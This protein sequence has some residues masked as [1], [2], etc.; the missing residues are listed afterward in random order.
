MSESEWVKNITLTVF[1][2]R[3]ISDEETSKPKIKV[4]IKPVQPNGAAPRF[5]SV[6]ELRSVVGNLELHPVQSMVSD[7]LVLHK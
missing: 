2:F 5:A 6:D 3:A 1:K 4:E 7:A